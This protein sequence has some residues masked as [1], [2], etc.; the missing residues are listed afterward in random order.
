TVLVF[1][2]GLA[3]DVIGLS[4]IQRFLVQIVVAVGVVYGGLSF[5]RLYVPL[6]RELDLGFWGG[7]VTVVWIVGVTN[8]INLLDGLDGLAGGV[9]AMIATS[10]LNF[11]WLQG[12]ALRALLMFASVGAWL[13]CLRFYWTAARN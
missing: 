5:G 12:N 8:A 7:F 6:W 13:G 10:V 9:A 3:D 2:T 1:L 4:C 11:A